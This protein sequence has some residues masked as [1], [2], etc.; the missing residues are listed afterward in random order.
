M[1]RLTDGLRPHFLLALLCAALYLPGLFTIPPLDR[2]EARF[3]EASRQML[4]SGDYATVRF[5]D[6]LRAKKP[7]GIYW[8]QALSAHITG[9]E[10]AIWSYRLPSALGALVAVL[11][12]FTFGQFL[13]GRKAALIGAALLAASPLLV[14][15]A[16]T[17]KTDAV[18]LV[19]LM[20]AQGMLAR[21]YLA[22][23]GELNDPTPGWGSALIFW[24][25]QAG[26]ILIKGPI[27]PM[28]SL[29]T[30][31]TLAIADRRIDWARRLRP[32]TGIVLVILLVAP[33]VIAV[34]MA[35]RGQFVGEAVNHDLLSK[36][37][38][39]AE[40]HGGMP[41][42]YLLLATLTLWP[43][44]L[45][46]GPGL[47]RAIG[48]RKAA[49]FRFCLAWIAPAWAVFELVP[50]KLPHYVLPL[51]PAL[52][53]LAG[54]AIADRH[55]ILSSWWMRAM[56][57]LWSIVT[58]AIAVAAVL[59]SNRY[60]LAGDPAAIA[61]CIAALTTG[62]AT[63]IPL[64]QG[65][66]ARAAW[67]SVIGAV[68]TIA[69]LLE[70]VVPRL[71]QLWVSARVAEIAS[72]HPIVAAGYHEPSLVFLMGPD[73]LLTEGEGAALFLIQHTDA[74]AVI[75]TAQEPAFVARLK[76]EDHAATKFAEVDGFNYSQGHPVH[77]GLWRLGAM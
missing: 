51:Y 17:A 68:V 11:L 42:T 12:T 70:G 57:V 66:Y 35:T 73:T 58:L 13:F 62:L 19:A 1:R 25:A 8:L 60:G 45:F 47:V 36:L 77:L 24:L 53:L 4:D 20:A 32:I 52:A 5:Q 71:D 76:K 6:E 61:T 7:A 3:A 40:S 10:D 46:A 39:P 55:K 75:E 16:H 69:L 63:L 18:L 34:S 44:S 64:T 72:G 38:A 65:R 33:W 27:V 28:V 30:L 2:D 21:F 54:S 56:A 26:G 29:L 23:R 14:V 22:G 43:A 15:E 50:T 9:Q 59:G 37:I 74:E 67:S 41:G 48:D 49:A 31:A